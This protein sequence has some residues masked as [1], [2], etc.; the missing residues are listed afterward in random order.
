MINKYILETVL[1]YTTH[2]NVWLPTFEEGEQF[3]IHHTRVSK[4]SAATHPLKVLNI[5]ARNSQ[6]FRKRTELF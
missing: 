4:L 1:L 5:S 3:N 6:I 2:G